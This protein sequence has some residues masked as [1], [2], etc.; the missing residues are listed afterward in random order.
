MRP[1]RDEERLRTTQRGKISRR[2]DKG[3]SLHALR[4][5]LQAGHGLQQYGVGE[6]VVGHGG[7]QLGE[8]GIVRFPGRGFGCALAQG[9]EPGVFEGVREMGEVVVEAFWDQGLGPAPSPPW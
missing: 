2:L 3:E 4:R 7:G 6:V 5:D 8:A 9:D 1:G